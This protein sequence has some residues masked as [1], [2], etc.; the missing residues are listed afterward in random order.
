[1]L[2]PKFTGSYL[3]RI[4]IGLSVH[5]SHDLVDSVGLIFV[6][7]FYTFHNFI[8]TDLATFT[9]GQGSGGGGGSGS[10]DGSRRSKTSRGEV[11]HNLDMRVVNYVLINYS[12]AVR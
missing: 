1:M 12:P 9:V 2:S 7:K 3:P 6:L 11:K 4:L 10:G 8:Q 5:S